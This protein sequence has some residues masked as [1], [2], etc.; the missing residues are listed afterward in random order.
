[1]TNQCRSTQITRKYFPPCPSAVI[2]AKL[3]S[4]VSMLQFCQ[5]DIVYFRHITAKTLS[6]YLLVLIYNIYLRGG[7]TQHGRRKTATLLWH[8]CDLSYEYNYLAVWRAINGLG[9]IDFLK[10]ECV[11][12]FNG[13]RQH[14]DDVTS[15]SKSPSLSQGQE[16]W[17]M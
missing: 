10:T 4:R 5:F 6:S 16:K 2:K 8:I 1:M 9:T 3:M 17:L 13:A 11:Q 7:T 12:I 14:V 15:P